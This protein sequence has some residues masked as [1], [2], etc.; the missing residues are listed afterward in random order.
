MFDLPENTNQ[1]ELGMT[2]LAIEDAGGVLSIQAECGCRL[3]SPAHAE[4][5]PDTSEEEENVL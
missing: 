1:L 3:T 4:C 2:P 5:G